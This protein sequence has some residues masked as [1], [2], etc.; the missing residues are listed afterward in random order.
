MSGDEGGVQHHVAGGN[1]QRAAGRHG[2]AGV[3]GQVQDHLFDLPGVGEHGLEFRGEIDVQRDVFADHALK[4][5]GDVGDVRAEVERDGGQH[6][7]AAEGEQLPRELG[8]A[9]AGLLDVLEFFTHRVPVGQVHQGDVGGAI[10]DGEQVVEVVRDAAGQAPDHF[11]LLRLRELF[12]QAPLLRQVPRDADVVGDG[13]SRVSHRG[14]GLRPEVQ[15]AILA[16][17]GQLAVPHDTGGQGLPHLLV[18]R[19]RMHARLDQLTRVLANRFSE[20]VSVQGSEG[21]VGPLDGAILVGDHNG[22]GRGIEG[23]A[24]QAQRRIGPLL[25]ADVAHEGRDKPA[26]GSFPLRERQLHGQLGSVLAQAL[27]LSNGHVGGGAAAGHPLHA[28]QVALLVTGRD[29]E[30]QRLAERFFFGVTENGRRR[31]APADDQI[32]AVDGHHGVVGR[33]HHRPVAAFTAAQLAIELVLVEG[34]LDGGPQVV[35]VERLDDVAE[36]VGRLGLLHHVVAGV[37]GEKDTGDRES[38]A[39]GD[40]RVNAA[41]GAGEVD[42]HQH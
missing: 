7:F 25:L 41:H 5:P 27:Q 22:I 37:G 30:H 9:V 17:V 20:R 10:D 18:E 14:D 26:T 32:R 34:N 3:Y 23:G 16:P 1:R 8:S 13:A 24:L 21:R 39:N 19:L 35:L 40:G 29:Q 28:G 2:V 36:R 31:R 11:H 42:V 15:G 12:A 6:L 33:P 4:Q 38:L